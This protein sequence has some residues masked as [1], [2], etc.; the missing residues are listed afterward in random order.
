MDFVDNIATYLVLGNYLLLWSAYVLTNDPSSDGGDEMRAGF[1]GLVGG[2][3]ALFVASFLVGPHLND[4]V[5]SM[6]MTL[7]SAAIL[8]GLGYHKMQKQI[9]E[10]GRKERKVPI[11]RSSSSRST[12]RK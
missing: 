11:I 7:L 1:V 12:R 6:Y 5:P 3:C 4:M 2:L 10:R 9:N 8:L